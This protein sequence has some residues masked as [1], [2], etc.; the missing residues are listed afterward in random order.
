MTSKE[1]IGTICLL[2]VVVV[3][4]EVFFVNSCNTSKVSISQFSLFSLT[5]KM[6]ST[7]PLC[8]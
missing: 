3:V 8:F 7:F 6:K 2:T 4:G 5:M 1:R